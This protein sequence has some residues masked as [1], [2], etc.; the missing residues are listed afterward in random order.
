MLWKN[1][2]GLSEQAKF[3]LFCGRRERTL[4]REVVR[5][6]DQNRNAV[7]RRRH[8]AAQEDMVAHELACARDGIGAD[9]EVP[10]RGCQ[11]ARLRVE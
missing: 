3:A 4:A 11:R 8:V 5:V 7:R 9:S 2:P 10:K 1:V 6:W